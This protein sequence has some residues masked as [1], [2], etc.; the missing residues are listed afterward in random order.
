MP[1]VYTIEGPK[2]RRSRRACRRVRMGKRGCTIEQCKN[3]KG[4]WRFKKGTME[5][6]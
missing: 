2:S 3:A 1:S 5:C 6:R 4:Q